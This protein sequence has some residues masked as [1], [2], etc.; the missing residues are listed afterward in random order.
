M[1]NAADGLGNPPGAWSGSGEESSRSSGG[2]SP[3]PFPDLVGAV[4]AEVLAPLAK[5]WPGPRETTVRKKTILLIWAV[6]CKSHWEQPTVTTASTQPGLVSALLHEIRGTHC[7]LLNNTIVTF[8][9]HPKCHRPTLVTLQGLALR[10]SC[11][12]MLAFLTHR[13]TLSLKRCAMCRAE[14]CCVHYKR[15]SIGF[16]SKSKC[17]YCL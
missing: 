2:L 17:F 13:A 11:L 15:C 9:H 5:I 3:S 7:Q 8:Q 12:E 6:C 10:F 1:L 4:T 14:R 16:S